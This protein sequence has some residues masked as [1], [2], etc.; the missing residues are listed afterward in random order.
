MQGQNNFRMFKFAKKL[1]LALTSAACCADGVQNLGYL[2]SCHCSIVSFEVIYRGSPHFLI[3][4]PK[5]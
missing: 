5:E 2:S 1:S 4:G 3:F